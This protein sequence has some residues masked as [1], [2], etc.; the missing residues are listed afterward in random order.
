M[1]GAPANE[2]G[3]WRWIASSM[4]SRSKRGMSTIA[5]PVATETPMITVRPYTWKSGI[6][7]TPRSRPSTSVGFH[8]RD[9]STFA[10]SARCDRT[11][12]FGTPVV[13]PVYWRIAVSSGR[14]S[15]GRRAGPSFSRSGNECSPAARSIGVRWPSR[16]SR[17]SVNSARTTGGKYSLMFVGIRFRTFVPS[18]AAR[19]TAWSRESATSVS[20][21]GPVELGVG[22]RPFDESMPDDRAEDRRDR[23]RMT[24][25]GVTE[26]LLKGNGG[27]GERARH[28]RVVVLPPRALGRDPDAQPQP[29]ARYRS[30]RTSSRRMPALQ[31]P[32]RQSAVRHVDSRYGD[33]R[34]AALGLDRL[35]V[36]A[37]GAAQQRAAIGAAEHAREEAQA[38]GRV[39]AIDDRATWRDAVATTRPRIRRP[40][41]A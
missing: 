27:I 19:A 8:E 38:G 3:R 10:T 41:V 21:P 13:P 26:E 15:T 34:V 4:C 32:L 24:R 28:A 29:P 2:R 14:T 16:R 12:P 5:L 30:T 39:D 1:R 40:D 35:V 36:P 17:A 31:R 9:C 33:H 23:P 25:G 11:A 37:G 20:V 22:Q 7:S 6:T 18:R